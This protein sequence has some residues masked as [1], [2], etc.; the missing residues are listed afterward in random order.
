MHRWTLAHSLKLFIFLDTVRQFAI[1]QHTTVCGRTLLL[2]ALCDRV[3]AR[4]ASSTGFYCGG[5]WYTLDR[6]RINAQGLVS[7]FGFEAGHIGKISIT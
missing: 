5:G 3:L 7:A 6:M 1:L 4:K 2:Q